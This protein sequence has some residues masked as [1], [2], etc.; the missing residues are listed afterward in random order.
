LKA[1]RPGYAEKPFF[2]KSDNRI[3]AWDA[4]EA[5]Q[6]AL[7]WALLD[8]FG[9][10]IEYLLKE[11]RRWPVPDGTVEEERWIRLTGGIEKPALAALVA[12]AERWFFGDSGFQLCVREA[13]HA[14]YFAYDEHGLFFLYD[15]P[16]AAALLTRMGYTER[17]EELISDQPHWEARPAGAADQLAL[18][19]KALKERSAFWEDE[20][21]TGDGV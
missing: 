12:G 4:E 9:P 6:K 7:F 19:K 14:G 1:M 5:R 13:E 16:D 2:F 18:F 3:V 8:G 17:Q 15:L 20:A 11:D 10:H 21:E